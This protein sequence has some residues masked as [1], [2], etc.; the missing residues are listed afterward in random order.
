MKVGGVEVKVRGYGNGNGN[1]KGNG[2]GNGTCIIRPCEE[3]EAGR[4]E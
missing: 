1:G 3:E 4:R 2:A